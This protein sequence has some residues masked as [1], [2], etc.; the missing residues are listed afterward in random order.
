TVELV[1]AHGTGTRVGDEVEFQ[2][3]NQLFGKSAQNGQWCAI[4]SVKSMIGHTKAAAGA[5]G[6]MK[7]VLS[8]YNKVL[9][10]TLKVDEPDPRLNIHQ[11]P[12]YLNTESRPWF[13]NKEHPRRSGISAFGFGGSNFHVV[14]EEYQS[15]K[16]EVSWD[17]SVEIVALSASNQKE[18][19]KLLQ[20]FK[21]SVDKGTTYEEIAA[22]AAKTRDN[23]STSDQH[24]LLIV[25]EHSMD[26]KSLF[27]RALHALES[28]SSRNPWHLK[29]IFYGGPETFD[30]I[31]FVFPGQGSQYVGM[32]RDLVSSF[33]DAFKVLE[34]ANEK[35]DNSGRLTDIIYPFSPQTGKDRQ[36]QEKTLRKTE[37]CQPAI[38][39]V[40]MAMLKILQGF[41][42]KPHATCGH[43]FGELSALCAAGRIDLDT[44]LHL[45]IARGRLMAAAGRDNSQNSGGMLAVKAPLDELDHLIKKTETG[46]ILANRNSPEQGVLSGSVEAIARAE[47][48]CNQKGF[49]TI[50]LPVSAAFHSELVKDAQEPFIQTLEK[51]DFFPSDIPV[52]SN[53]TGKPYPK[54]SEKAKKLLGRHLLSPVDFVSEIKN[55]FK[56]GVQTFVEVGPKTVLTGL[57]KSILKGQ[58]FQAIAVDDSLG[59]RSGT[60]DLAGTLCHLASLGH[61]VDL[62]CWEQPAKETRKQVMSIPIAGV[63][64]RS[65][66][67]EVRSQGSEIRDQRSGIRD[68]GSEEERQRSK[69]RRQ[70]TEIRTSNTTSYI[71]QG[72]ENRSFNINP[73]HENQNTM[74]NKQ[75]QQSFILD[76]LNVVQQGLKSM[77]ELQ[78]QTAETHQKFLETQTQAARTLQKM[79]E[80]TQRLAET[81]LGIKTQID[82]HSAI[83]TQHDSIV[84]PVSSDSATKEV[85]F[86]K[87]DLKPDDK[88][89]KPPDSAPKE[90]ENIMLDVVSQLTGYPTEMLA[91]DMDIEADLGIDSIK[92]VEILSTLEEKVPNLP[93]VSPEIMGS[94]KTLGQIVQ[95]LSGA[96]DSHAPSISETK[97]VE[98]PTVEHQEL[99][100][101]ML[102]TV[103]RLTGYPTEMLA[104]DM[105]IEA[106]LGIDSIKRVEI[107]ST[108]EEKVP[109]LPT[110]SPEIMGSMKTLGQIVQYLSGT[111][112]TDEPH[113]KTKSVS[114]TSH[115]DTVQKS[116][117]VLLEDVVDFSPEYLA[118]SIGRKVVS[119]VEKPF[120]NND[121]LALPANR[122]VFITD[123]KTGLSEALIDRFAWLN[124]NAELI[125][126]GMFSDIIKGDKIVKNAAGLVI[127]HESRSEGTRFLK[128]V[129][130]LTNRLAPDL[131]NSAAKSAALFA[132]I[133]RLDGAFGFKGRGVDNPLQ[134]GL[135]G[136]AKTASLEWDDVLC[137]AIDIAPAWKEN[138]KIAKAVVAELL[139]P[140]LKGPVEI[141][142]DSGSRSTFE[143][144][145][146]PFPQGEINLNPYDVV[147][148]T[149]GARGVTASA[150][151]ALAKRAK[152]TLVLM[153]RSL[154]PTPEPEWLKAMDDEAGIKKAILENEFSGNNATPV[155]LEKL[156]K[157]HMANREITKN[158]ENMRNV[159]ATVLYYQADIRDFDKVNSILNDVRSAHGPVR[160]IIHGAGTLE[161][162]LIIDKTKEQFENV[163]DPKVKGLS[164]LLEA[165][166][167]DALKYIVLF[168]S[169]TARIGNN[170]QADYAMANEVLNKIAQQEST[171][172]PDCK[173]ISINWGPWDGGMVCSALKRKLE[174]NGVEL[175]PMDAGAMCM[176]YEMMGDRNSPVEVVV[177][178]NIIPAKE[179]DKAQLTCLAPKQ[180]IV[181]KKKEKLSL[182]FEREIDVNRYPILEAH[183][184]GGKPVVPF[185]LIAEWL[186]HGALHENPGLFL[187]GL[188]DM[189]ILHG[190]KLDQEKKIIRL[191]TGKARK[192]GSTFE[193]D[194]E[195][196]D[197]IK[198]NTEI[199]HS[200]ATAILTDKTVQP[201]N[202]NKSEHISSNSYSRSIHE[203]YEKI[204]FH[205][206]ELRGIQEIIGYSSRGMTAR[207]SSAPS[208]EKWMTDPLRSRWIGDPL[209]L[210]SAFQMAI[211]WCFE[212]RNVV[213]LPS[214][215][216]SYRQ[217]R[218]SFPSDGVTAF[219]EVKEVTD[220]KMKGDFTFI[221]SED[222]VIARLTGYEAVMDASLSKAF[223]ARHAA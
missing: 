193:V 111:S 175:I 149:G 134:G 108:L 76:A 181:I 82:A 47:K 170:G 40:S 198:D 141:G 163:F 127:V 129:F 208:P 167:Q 1:E 9:P 197:G 205:G 132:T 15:Q 207:I 53:T 6:L 218:D 101:I 26:L 92:R 69:G 182:T 150:A 22:K 200:R 46:A 86:E 139:N 91:M 161:D 36:N 96:T 61:T 3:L 25:I 57:V 216:A 130:A 136:L 154:P 94:M 7:A 180:P 115:I 66:R 138:N 117:D 146:A 164:A 206:I 125:S 105:D 112:Q 152:P 214:Y 2:A 5:A 23:F 215:S 73:I 102:E 48:I 38:G 189:R 77:Q 34:K 114:S 59:Q 204:L 195:I 156:Y 99:E 24:R 29:N 31:A 33:P 171:T 12:F 97:D 169:V 211:L 209:V 201:P 179:K 133:T 203:I 107:L 44:M 27:D 165:T 172:R 223:K 120:N 75:P 70:S 222:V 87:P 151:C 98:S 187:H 19:A 30:K 28:K 159:G 49:R 186:G 143:L 194:V 121:R 128:D 144:E 93:T 177:G 196:R 90:L 41:G 79:M 188:D 58:N 60:E 168:S 67:S 8:V 68:Q 157:K 220:Y 80:N 65:Q 32:F 212:E 72:Q 14:V 84:V 155:Q 20:S 42:I 118:A 100:N 64:Y 85:S 43:S 95:Y 147:V 135:A 190:I 39:A 51:I 71:E 126:D 35:Y 219:L 10:P 16:Q 116:P 123:D 145:A 183:I 4:G 185:A 178:A 109:N 45:S 202:F 55:L 160:G 122:K 103:S 37:I 110:V 137:R 119:M 78:I 17:G 81:S 173:V 199:I 106:D 74:K 21:T 124:I 104:M 192:N 54:D 89:P 18:L 63:N 13:S 217:Y 131:L 210:D 11:S 184:L 158:L 142:L 176:I 148:I 88:D 113:K 162:R 166:K 140:D 52:F 221:D 62:S 56:M 191:L 83:Q 50:K 174:N 153:G 213:S